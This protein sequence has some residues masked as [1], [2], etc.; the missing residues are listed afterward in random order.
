MLRDACDYEVVRFEFQR[1]GL[2][3]ILEIPAYLSFLRRWSRNDDFFVIR[4]FSAAMFPLSRPEFGATIVHHIDTTGSSLVSAA[5]QRI[6]EWRFRR[7]NGS[8]DRIVTI[9][10]YWRDYFRS[11][12]FASVPLIHCAYDVDV[13]QASPEQVADFKRRHGLE[14]DPSS[15][16]AT[17]RGRRG[18]SR[19]CARCRESP[20]TS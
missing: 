8:R 15:T 17:R 13:Y 2:W 18:F 12:G 3:R 6:L 5:V 1:V 10:E 20:T 14:S 11:L 19:S 9:S 7:A 4:G 16:S